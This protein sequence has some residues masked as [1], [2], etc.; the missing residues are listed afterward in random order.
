MTYV[1][2]VAYCWATAKDPDVVRDPD[3][4]KLCVEKLSSCPLPSL[5]L[6]PETLLIRPT[7]VAD[8]LDFVDAENDM[9]RLF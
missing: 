1:L 3:V 2:F 9:C 8:V 5:A 4:A 7:L 6:T